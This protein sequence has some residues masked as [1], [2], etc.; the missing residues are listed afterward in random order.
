MRAMGTFVDED[1]VGLEVAV[2]DSQSVKRSQ[3][4]S[5]L[6]PNCGYIADCAAL[7]PVAKWGARD[8][9]FD[10]AQPLG[11]YVRETVVS[12][13]L[14]QLAYTHDM[15]VAKTDEEGIFAPKVTREI[16][17]ALALKLENDRLVAKPS[18]LRL[19]DDGA[20][21]FSQSIA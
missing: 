8:D 15:G 11:G 7:S 10:Q 18:I 20:A 5:N 19:V 12:R 14:D 16:V 3:G 17:C 2:A 9:I 13:E 21:A 4:A 6:S 1:V